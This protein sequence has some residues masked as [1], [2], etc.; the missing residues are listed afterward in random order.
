MYPNPSHLTTSIASLPECLRAA[1][2]STFNGD[3]TK[4][5]R[6]KQSCLIRFDSFRGTN[7]LSDQNLAWLGKSTSNWI[8]PP[9]QPNNLM[10]SACCRKKENRL[11]LQFNNLAKALISGR[12]MM[13]DAGSEP[14]SRYL[15]SIKMEKYHE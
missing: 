3:R 9:G 11:H 14:S 8:N 13:N 7:T 15:F 5:K 2:P 10:P 6:R 4:S 12:I 1:S